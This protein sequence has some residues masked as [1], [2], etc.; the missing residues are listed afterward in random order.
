MIR[1]PPRS[2][3]LYS[4]AASDVYKRQVVQRDASTTRE[5]ETR[6]D[7]REDDDDRDD[8]SDDDS[9]VHCFSSSSRISRAALSIVLLRRLAEGAFSMLARCLSCWRTVRR[10]CVL[11]R[12]VG[13]LPADTVSPVGAAS[14]HCRRCGCR[15]RDVLAAQP[16]RD[17]G[18]DACLLYTSDAA[19]E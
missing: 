3:P 15:D 14:S 12:H 19:D 6:D 11:I 5:D 7:Q 18:R 17:H 10:R 2:T 13:F 8:D 1:R 16:L 4:S 9:G